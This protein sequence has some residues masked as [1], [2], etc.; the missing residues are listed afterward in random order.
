MYVELH[1]YRM[2]IQWLANKSVFIQTFLSPSVALFRGGLQ[3]LV[4]AVEAHVRQAPRV[5]VVPRV[6]SRTQAARPV[7]CSE[8][9]RVS[10]HPREKKKWN[11]TIVINRLCSK[12]N[13]SQNLRFSLHSHRTLNLRT[14]P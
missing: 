8:M 4:T 5:D 9:G 14:L 7:E 2:E 3:G 12:K 10:R 11:R 1:Y 13:Q 6:E